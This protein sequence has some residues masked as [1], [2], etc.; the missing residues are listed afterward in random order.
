[1]HEQLDGLWHVER[2]CGL[3]W[4]PET[5]SPELP[6]WRAER[7]PLELSKVRPWAGF[8]ARS[9]CCSTDSIPPMEP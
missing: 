2:A 5:P 8:S 3:P 1:M 4:G 7:P 6:R 9:G